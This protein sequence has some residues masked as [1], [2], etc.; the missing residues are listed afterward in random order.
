MTEI[1]TDRSGNSYVETP[2]A[3]N[4]KLRITRIA[5]PQWAGRDTV[6]I[7]KVGANGHLF[8]GPEVP[9]D[10]VGDLLRGLFEVN[11]QSSVSSS[12]G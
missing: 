2:M 1:A 7:Q 5:S 4:E 3:G 8:P 6:R 10:M 9:V 11:T 12:A